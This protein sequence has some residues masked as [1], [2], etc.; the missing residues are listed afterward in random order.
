MTAVRPRSEAPPLV[1]SLVGIIV[2]VVSAVFGI[3][4]H[5]LAAG[6]G[7]ALPSSGQMLMVLAASAG[8]GG[9]TAALARR[10]SPIAL[11]A[12]GLLAGQ[13]VVHLVM[14][15]GHGHSGS[16]HSGAHPAAGGHA[17]H[18]PDPVAVRAAMDGTAATAGTGGASGAGAAT[19]SHA[20]ALLTPAMLGAH[21]AA[22]VI[23]LAL[24]A[25]L[26][27]TLAWVAARVLPLLATAH[28]VV[29]ELTDPHGRIA[30]PDARY[31]LARGRPR[32]PPVS[33]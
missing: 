23:T 6:T 1:T 28:L 2:A 15:S 4:A 22:I 14:I 33:V 17:G 11:T 5:G 24:V 32:A 21:L 31:L 19:G 3:S 13:G 7:A 18:M 29:V 8:I 16:A 26:S 25:I 27:G 9:A 10:R 30:A 20:D 12:G